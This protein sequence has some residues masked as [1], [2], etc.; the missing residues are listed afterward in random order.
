M[1]EYLIKV[2]KKG[3]LYPPK[4]LRIDA[5]ITPGSEFIAITKN[6][7]IVLRKRKTIADILE[8]TAITTVSIAEL[9]AQRKVLEKRLSER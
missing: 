4:Q 1:A 5:D 3:E 6:E 2:G 8:D 9:K 7:K